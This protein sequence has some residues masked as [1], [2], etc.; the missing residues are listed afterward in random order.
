MTELYIA[1]TQVVLPTEFSTTVKRENSLF[2]KNGEYSYDITL[3][4]T[5]PVNAELY[6]HLNRINTVD[7]I[8]Q[9]RPLI[10]IAD[11]RVY[12]N[13]T[14]II[15]AWT[16]TTV[17]IQAASGNSELNYFIGSELMISELDMPDISPFMPNGQ[18]NKQY[19][20]KLYPEIDIC[21]PLIYNSTQGE[22]VN[23]WR[24]NTIW[25]TKEVELIHK[26][27]FTPEDYM[28]QVF[29]CAYIKAVIY[30][31]G[32]E[33][34]EN[35]IS[36]SLWKDLYIAQLNYTTQWAKMLPGWTVGEFLEEIENLFNVTFIIDSRS[37]SARLLF[38][39][40]YYINAP[41]SHVTHVVDEYE[42]E[43]IQDGEGA[44]THL[45]VN[46]RY[47]FPDTPYFRKRR[48]PELVSKNVKRD[49]I[50]KEFADGQ[51]ILGYINAWFA[52]E[53]HKRKDIIYTD[54]LTGR[55]YVYSGDNYYG[56]ISVCYMVNE[57]KDIEREEASETIELNIM[58][59]AMEML[60]GKTYTDG[61]P[62]KLLSFPL[63]V[64]TIE[65][66]AKDTPEEES[67]N[68]M[69]QL[70]D[71][72]SDSGKES[73]SPI[74]VAFHQGLNNFNAGY[75]PPNSFPLSFTDDLS[76]GIFYM[77]ITNAQGSTLRLAKLE[78]E[79]YSGIYKIDESKPRT[80][81]SYDPNIYDPRNIFVIQNKR[82]VCRDIEYTIQHDGRKEAWK[83]TFYPIDIDDSQADAR[84]ILTD[85][86]WRDSGVWIDS[87][88]WNDD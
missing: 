71:G 20:E 39:N 48:M 50:P 51:Y 13:G 30:A 47:D 49:V 31:I 83:G 23:E 80:F 46:I 34:T 12:C 82:W 72:V 77:D 87:G 53:S 57:Y 27:G 44:K 61:E 67:K 1:G 18:P 43:S 58:P 16:D 70:E 60:P 26:P 66:N 10:L 11:N 45:N 63:L 52:I 37:K 88:R 54:E 76:W 84:W 8:T 24:S 68:I 22:L 75:F 32:Y 74:Y 35:A 21:L 17:T 86:K 69:E 62:N 85:G 5:N 81:V 25:S 28:P 14:E 55:E 4:L 6:K 36:E 78:K 59:V 79:L 29:L 38:N 41:T 73:K 2:T 40:A 7:E 33:L 65:N 9:N 3:D 42:G 64:P 15:T 56:Y 19:V